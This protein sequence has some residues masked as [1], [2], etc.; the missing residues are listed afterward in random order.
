MEQGPRQ[1]V[2]EITDGSVQELLQKLLRA[3][4]VLAERRRRS[5]TNEVPGR[6]SHKRENKDQDRGVAVR[7]STT[8]A[9]SNAWAQGTAEATLKHT[10]CFNCSKKGHLA[11]IVLNLRRMLH[12]EKQILISRKVTLALILGLAQ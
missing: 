12:V 11:K 8:R 9:Q 6:M 1:E 5:Q 7:E 10:K 2:K 3:E 4:S